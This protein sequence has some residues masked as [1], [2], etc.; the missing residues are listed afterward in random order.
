MHWNPPPYMQGSLKLMF[1]SAFE[2]FVN[3]EATDTL[4][5]GETVSANHWCY[6]QRVTV[7]L[8]WT[9]LKHSDLTNSPIIRHASKLRS[10]DANIKSMVT[11]KQT[12][13]VNLLG[14]LAVCVA[15]IVQLQNSKKMF[16][17][18]SESKSNMPCDWNWNWNRNHIPC[19]CHPHH[20]ILLPAP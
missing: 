13:V 7:V 17:V 1:T 5:V 20:S 15:V 11:I 10:I 8:I 12:I 9:N 6:R 16:K 18:E 19:I 4:A 3:G 14:F 2:T